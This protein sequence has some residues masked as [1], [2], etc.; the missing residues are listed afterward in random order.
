M[1]SSGINWIELLGSGGGWTLA[2]AIGWAVMTGKLRLER[3]F[4][5][6]DQRVEKLTGQFEQAV[7]K[8]DDANERRV[9]ALIAT[10]DRLHKR[11]DKLAGVSSDERGA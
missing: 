3:E 4:L 9:E 2:I 10:N 1:D 7:A 11:L 8:I 5:D 6:R